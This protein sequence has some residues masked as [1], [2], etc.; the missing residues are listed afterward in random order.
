VV[1]RNGIFNARGAI[2][3][4]SASLRGEYTAFNENLR[5][6]AGL[7]SNT[8]N[9]PDET[10]I[11]KEFAAT[12]KINKKHLVRAVFSQSPRSSAIFDAFVD[13]YAAY[14]PLGPNLATLIRLEGNKSLKMLH[15]GMFEIGYRGNILPGLNIE[16]ELFRTTSKN[17]SMMVINK[18][19]IETEGMDTTIVVPLRATN[20]P[21]QIA[22]NGITVSLDYSPGKLRFKP[23]IT[24][25]GTKVKDYAPYSV[26]PDA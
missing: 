14:Q 18:T 7:A 25:Q 8:F 15:A 26:T 9:Y 24:V 23:F 4:K 3:T 2:T 6:V 20:I 21:M 17:Y 5:L 13:Q 1:N 11:S 22:Q 10:Y 19:Y 12:Y 16:V